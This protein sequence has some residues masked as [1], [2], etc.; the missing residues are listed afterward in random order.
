VCGRNLTGKQMSFNR[1]TECGNRWTEKR[2]GA[3]MLLQMVGVRRFFT[4]RYLLK[5]ASLKKVSL[6]KLCFKKRVYFE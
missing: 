1:G 4:A 5:K 2:R 6:K 3:G